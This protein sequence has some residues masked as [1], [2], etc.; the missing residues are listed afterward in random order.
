MKYRIR[1]Q[2]EYTHD[3]LLP[4][5]NHLDT[6]AKKATTDPAAAAVTNSCENEKNEKMVNWTECL[7][8]SFCIP[9]PR[10]TLKQYEMRGVHH[11]N[12]PL[13]IM[14]Y[15]STYLKSMEESQLISSVAE[16]RGET[17]ISMMLGAF[18]GCERVLQTPLPVAYNIAISQITWLYVMVSL[19]YI[20]S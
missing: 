20:I 8:L 14:N 15:L 2:P 6:Y 7:G 10:K 5:I 17:S 16:G 9:N 11:G 19:L 13:E 4:L 12:L 18:G 1:H 3:G